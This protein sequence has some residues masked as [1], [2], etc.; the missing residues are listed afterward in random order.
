MA[1]APTNR[2]SS[3]TCFGV[4]AIVPS[5][6][7]ATQAAH[8]CCG[9]ADLSVRFPQSMMPEKYDRPNNMTESPD[10]DHEAA[11]RCL[12]QR[13]RRLATGLL[14]FAATMFAILP[15]SRWID[16]ASASRPDT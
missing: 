6:H 15:L 8:A 16:V 2:I 3:F 9:E 10:T 7:P 1:D 11:Q 5:N 4:K 14:L 13:N 12:L